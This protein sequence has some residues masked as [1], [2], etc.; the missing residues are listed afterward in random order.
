M[1]EAELAAYNEKLMT[2]LEDPTEARAKIEVRS[3]MADI[4]SSDKTHKVSA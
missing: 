4:V 1:I 2:I 3:Y